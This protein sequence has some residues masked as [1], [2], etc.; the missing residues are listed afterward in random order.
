MAGADFSSTLRLKKAI[1]LRYGKL[2]KI[3]EEQCYGCFKRRRDLE[4]AIVEVL[5]GGLDVED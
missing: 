1:D 5:E 4:S 3:T 2:A